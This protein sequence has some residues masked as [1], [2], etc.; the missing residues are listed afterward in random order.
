MKAILLMTVLCLLCATLCYAQ[1]YNDTA[2]HHAYNS[3]IDHYKKIL[4][5]ELGLYNGPVYVD[6]TRTISQGSSFL[7]DSTYPS[8]GNV[9]YDGVLYE[10]I[11][12]LYDIYQNKLITI[13]PSTKISF[14]FVNER[15]EAFTLLGSYFYNLKPDSVYTIKPGYYERLYSGIKSSAYQRHEK[16]ARNDLSDRIVKIG[17]SD[18]N[19][20]F[21]KIKD[22]V[23]PVSRKKDILK[24][25]D[26]ERKKISHFMRTEKLRFRNNKR[27][28]IIKITRFYNE[29]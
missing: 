16:Q 2:S 26:N 6:Y 10:N 22:K 23:T 9:T 8:Y 13:H 19:V 27:E 5:N 17:L 12:L 14:S 25:Y 24:L 15:V 18:K 3:T 1:M 29:L 4:G 21:I 11:P 28:D 7:G 20:F